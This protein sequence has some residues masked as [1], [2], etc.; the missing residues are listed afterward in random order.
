MKTKILIFT[1]CFLLTLSVARMVMLIESKEIMLD[2]IVEQGKTISLY[3]KFFNE[4]TEYVE[5]KRNDKVLLTNLKDIQDYMSVYSTEKQKGSS[6]KFYNE[7]HSNLQNNIKTK[8]IA[9]SDK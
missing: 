4:V 5:I 1:L 9:K 2:T 3:Q 7:I 8:E 6:S